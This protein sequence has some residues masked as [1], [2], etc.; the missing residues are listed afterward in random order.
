MP[1]R[2]GRGGGGSDRRIP[3]WSDFQLPLPRATAKKVEQL[4]RRPIDGA[5]LALWLDK[6]V[7]REKGSFDLKATQRAFALNQFC[8]SYRSEV[9]AVAAERIGEA[10]TAHH[11]PGMAQAFRAA[12]DGRLLIGY[13]RANAVETS[14]TFHH[15]WGVPVIPGSA[16][17]G[18]ARARATLNGQLDEAALQRAFG[19]LGQRG[20]LVFYDAI[21]DQGRFEL[22]LDV[23]TP[24]AREYYEGHAPPADWLSPSPHTFLTI[25]KTT[26]VFVIGVLGSTDPRELSEGVKLLKGALED[27]GV[28]AKTAAGY[29]RFRDFKDA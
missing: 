4:G 23:L 1:P 22:G 13:G 17:K 11:E 5:N 24:H 29:G 7:W 16:L 20:Q 14:L 19:D 26:F 6:L 9:G 3:E 15:T 12:I 21:P 28:G 18:I 8:R 2:P 27:D 25:I 10:A